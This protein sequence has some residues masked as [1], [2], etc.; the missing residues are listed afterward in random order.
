MIL[1][2]CSGDKK[3]AESLH[4]QAIAAIEAS[5]PAGAL[6][7]LDSLDHTYPAEV[8]IRR[9]AMPLRPKAIELQTLRDLEETDSLLAQTQ[10]V[11]ES[12]DNLVKFKKA[13]RALT[14]ILLQHPC[15]MVCHRRPR[16]FIPA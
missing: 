11:I 14:A 9:A 8:D 7:L 1:T 2:S 15:P 5:D 12:M 6:L 13:L 10:V 3:A 16:V 4:N